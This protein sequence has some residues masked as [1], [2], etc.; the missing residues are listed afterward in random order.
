MNKTELH[1]NRIFS[2]DTPF[3]FFQTTSVN[4]IFPS[5]L[6]LQNVHSVCEDNLMTFTPSDALP[7]GDIWKSELS[8]LKKPTTEGENPEVRDVVD[9][10]TP[11][12]QPTTT[13][14]VEMTK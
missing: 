4:T 1:S 6:T 11:I 3:Q 5:C 8:D 13:I 7:S 2:D 9:N 10:T 12:I 14:P